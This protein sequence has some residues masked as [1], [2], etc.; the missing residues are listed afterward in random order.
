MGTDQLGRDILARSI[1]GARLSFAVGAA[2]M[3]L[4]GLVGAGSG[5]LSGYFGGWLE[6]VTMRLWD[7]LLAFPGALLG[8]ATAAAIGP[9]THSVV[10]AGALLGVP[11]FARLARASTLVEKERDY[12]LAARCLGARGSR[13]VCAHLPTPFRRC[14]A[15][16]GLH[17]RRS[18]SRPR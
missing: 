11:F 17:A 4:G 14:G 7:T 8:I 13:I 1:A 9:G 16:L 15:G 10:I 18:C 2:A 6:A 5:L 3:L 12:V